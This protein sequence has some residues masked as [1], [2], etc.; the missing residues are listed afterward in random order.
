[1]IKEQ[2]EGGKWNR[3]RTWNG[4]PTGKSMLDA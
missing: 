4:P 2:S 1:M 3:R